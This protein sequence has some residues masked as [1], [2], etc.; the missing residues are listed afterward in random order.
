MGRRQATS[1]EARALAN[2]LR[3]RILRLC[4]NDELT[5]SEI[6]RRL[7]KD[8]G[9]VLHHVRMLVDSGFL[10]ATE[11]RQGARGAY[12]KPYRATGKSWQVS[13]EDPAQA[14]TAQ[15]AMVQAFAEELAEA[16][17]A[18]VVRLTRFANRLDRTSYAELTERL[19]ALVEE[20]ALRDDPGGSRFAFLFGA[21]ARDERPEWAADTEQHDS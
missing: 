11:V 17:P 6:A 5:N 12:E 14:G 8:P 4:L 15:A 21:H 7:D 13:V 18:R 3:L 20:F 9:T 1:D 16:G 10:E 2:P 19:D